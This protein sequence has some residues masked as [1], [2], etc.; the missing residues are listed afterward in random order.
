MRV[1]VYSMHL[2]SRSELYESYLCVCVISVWLLDRLKPVAAGMPPGATFP[3][4]VKV[5]MNAVHVVTAKN[6]RIF[7]CLSICRL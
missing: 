1:Y 2:Y 3:D 5:C 7:N 6:F 4:V